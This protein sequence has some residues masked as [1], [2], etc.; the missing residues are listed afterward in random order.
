MGHHGGADAARRAVEVVGP[1]AWVVDGAGFL[2]DGKSSPGVV[3]QY[4]G[5]LGKVADCQIGVSVHSVTDTAPCP[6]GWRLYLPR[7]WDDQAVD[8]ADQPEVAAR[9]ESCGVPEDERHRPK[10]SLVVEMLDELAHHGLHPPL[11]AATPAT[12]NSASSTAP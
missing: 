3:R 6:L 11:P 12:G 7:S 2:K 4:S 8:E 5:T 9:R 10:W 1:V